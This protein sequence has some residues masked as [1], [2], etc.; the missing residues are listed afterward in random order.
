MII[1]GYTR[2]SSETDGSGKHTET[3]LVPDDRKLRDR[4]MYEDYA[5]TFD[6]VAQELEWE[7]G[8]DANGNARMTEDEFMKE[9]SSDRDCRVFGLIQ[10][11][12]SH[13]QYEP[14]VRMI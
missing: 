5:D 10:A 6:A 2:V 12:E 4:M 1:Y 8:K 9:L 7:D 14:F 3:V 13:V 11:S